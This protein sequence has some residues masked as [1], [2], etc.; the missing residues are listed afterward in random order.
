M[1]C[2]S[3]DL[4]LH[5][6][7]Q[8]KRKKAAL[9]TKLILLVIDVGVFQASSQTRKALGTSRQALVLEALVSRPIPPYAV[10]YKSADRNYVF[11]HSTSGT[12]VHISNVIAGTETGS[13]ATRSVGDASV[14]ELPEL[15]L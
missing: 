1:P 8:I 12:T 10:Q 7:L 13:V 2:T 6:A 11:N 3:T 4:G 15:R 9:R 14:R 5:A